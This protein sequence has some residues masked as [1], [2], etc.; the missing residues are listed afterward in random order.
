MVGGDVEIVHRAGQIEIAVGVEPLDERRALIAQIALDLEIRIE[1]ES[2]QVAILHA[3][4]EFPVQRRVRQISDVGG[5]PRDRESAMRMSALVAVAAAAPVRIGHHGLAAELVEGDVLRRVPR[6]AGDR[7]SRKDALRIGRGPL[8]DLHAAHRT[9]DHAEQRVDAEAIEQHRLCAHHVRNGDDR[10]IEA[11]QF[12]GRGIDRGR[13]G[14]AHAAADHIGADDVVAIGIER[15][16]GSDHGFP[17][18]GLAGD[19]M[20]IGDM[21][22]A[23]QRMADQNGVGALG[24]ERAIG[25]IGDLERRQVDT[26]IERQRLIRAEFRD[27]RTRVIRLVRALL[28]MDRLTYDR[29]YAHHLFVPAQPARAP[30]ARLSGH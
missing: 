24:V 30:K 4:A 23:G 17:P 28:A 3:P 1:G 6:R 14:R 16:A 25:L 18:A 11:P 15:P 29:L 21:L 27:R 26:A 5:H 9:A 19:R 13:P 10:K 20:H 22:I 7:Q 12:S 8:Q 2:R